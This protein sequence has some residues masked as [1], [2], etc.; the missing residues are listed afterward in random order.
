MRAPRS[1]QAGFTYIG[2]LVTVVVMG[3]MLTAVSRVW[4]TTEQREKETQLL[5]VGDQIRMAIARYYASSHHYPMSLQDLLGDDAPQPRRY[6][7]RLYRDPLM[8]DDDWILVPDPTGVGIMGVASRSKLVPLKR[9]GFRD[10]DAGFADSNCYCAWQFV[11]NPPSLY[12]R[13]TAPSR[14]P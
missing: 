7:R 11:Y 12:R 1:F 10:S 14:H 6:L 5:F 3:I 8:G 4:S 2:I 9:T 13:Y